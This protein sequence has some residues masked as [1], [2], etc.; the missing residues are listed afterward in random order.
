M[1]TC[2]YSIQRPSGATEG[3]LGTSSQ[4]VRIN[5]NNGF[6]TPVGTPPA[7]WRRL[8]SSPFVYVPAPLSNKL[9]ALND[10]QNSLAAYDLVT[11]QAEILSV[12]LA[13]PCP[14]GSITSFASPF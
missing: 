10:A 11:G 13:S 3:S 8:V 6:V 4:L 7:G 14:R 5:F 2:E 9:Y 12:T 1:S